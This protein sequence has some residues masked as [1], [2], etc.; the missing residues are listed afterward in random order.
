MANERTLQLSELRYRRVFEAAH[1]GILILNAG[2]GR[3]EDANPFMTELLGYTHDQFL[4]KHLWEIG[5]FKDIEQSKTAFHELQEKGYI[6][7]EDLPLQ[8]KN[9]VHRQVEFVSN[10][11]DVGDQ[12]ATV[13]ATSGGSGNGSELTVR[14]PILRVN[15]IVSEEADYLPHETRSF[16]SQRIL[17]V[18]D[19]GPAADIVAILLRS[20]G[21]QVRTAGS[22]AE[23]LAMIEQEQ[24]H[25]IISDISM[26]GMDGYEL[27]QEIRR[28]PDWNDIRLVAVTGYGQESDK[29]AAKEAGF[30]DHLVKPIGIK[31]LEGLLSR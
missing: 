2:T 4:G 16:P 20:R 22:G 19:L 23:A 7:Y 14:L 15:D 17:V 1:D 9:G 28:R 25:L 18:D 31:H 27:A 3:I 12:Q 10:I 11:Y 8:D 13:A 5:L 30:D 29:K 6:R 21:Q 24:P 26:P